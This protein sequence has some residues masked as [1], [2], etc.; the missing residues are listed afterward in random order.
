MSPRGLPSGV[1]T[2]FQS[3]TPKPVVLVDLRTG[4]SPANLRWTMRG[5]AVT[6]GGVVFSPRRFELD[7]ARVTPS[8]Q[9]ATLRLRVD[10]V[11]GALQALWA[12]GVD[13]VGKRCTVHRTN[14]GSTGGSGTDALRDVYFVDGW[15]RVASSWAFVL[16]PLVSVF[17]E[18][19]PRA[20]FSKAE[21]PGIPSEAS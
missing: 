14:L 9:A 2:D 19:A 6:F 11:D 1:S 21:F 13:F 8:S 15:E 20:V 7:E 17:D 10:D 16:K 5:E 18:E 3:S 4:S 12:A